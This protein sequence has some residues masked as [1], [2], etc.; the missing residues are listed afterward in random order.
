MTGRPAFVADCMLGRLAR[1]LRLLGYDTL[2]DPKAEDAR[3][4]R[5]AAES[6]RI[7]LTRDTRLA[8]LCRPGLATLLIRANDFRAQLREV[9]VAWA[10]DREGFLSRCSLCN[11]P[12]EEITREEA[13]GVVPDH[14]LAAVRRFGRCP[15]CRRTYWGGSHL[16]EMRRTLEFLPPATPRQG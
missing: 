7:L 2:Y 4:V 3:L 10:L 14:V 1:W 11:R 12:L 13:S 9:A 6:G 5:L 8:A 16:E 15:S